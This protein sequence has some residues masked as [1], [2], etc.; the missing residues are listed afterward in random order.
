MAS[1]PERT[2]LDQETLRAALLGPAGPYAALDV[3]ATTGSTNADL[4]AAAQAGAPDRAV[5]IAEE[6]TGGRGRQSRSW[7]SPAGAGLY[8]SVL[9][10]P[11]GVSPVHF[12]WLPLLAGL[13]LTRV[14]RATAGVTAAMKWP[15]DL[16]VGPA[17]RKCSGIL[18]EAVTQPPPGG[19]VSSPAVVVG[20]GLNVDHRPEELPARPQGPEATSLHAEGAVGLDRV[21]L[22]IDLLRELDA[23]ERVWRSHHGDVV[24]SGQLAA[25]R[26]ASATLGRRVRV[27]LAGDR[28]VLG[29]AVDVDEA[30]RL[31][32]RSDTGQTE[33]YSAGD[34][35]HLRAP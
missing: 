30:G 3:V 19:G 28:S 7:A 5:L 17:E 33:A 6:Q 11:E 26:Q 13:A 14:V 31:V 24:R 27:E 22:A 32:V 1:H 21:A 10:R 9:V 18:A 34:V 16:L 25:C 2:P 29:T 4:V 35:V 12:G 8:L 15:N 23:V 20:L